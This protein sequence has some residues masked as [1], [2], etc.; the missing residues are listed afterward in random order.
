MAPGRDTA[1]PSGAERQ[2]LDKWLWHARFARTRT[3]AARLVADGHV[4]VNGVRAQAPARA[5]KRDDVLTLALVRTAIA[6]RIR[7]FAERRG[8]A[9]E[10]RHL[11]E[12]L[13]PAGQDGTAPPHAGTFDPSGA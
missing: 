9:D 7:D 11:Y 6:V 2:R 10:A 1:G 12:L 13:T 3:L 5:V 4:R 8:P